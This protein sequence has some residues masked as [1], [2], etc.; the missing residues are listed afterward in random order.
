MKKKGG[1]ASEAEGKKAK[2]TRRCHKERDYKRKSWSLLTGIVLVAR[3]NNEILT[4]LTFPPHIGRNNPRS[5]FI[6]IRFLRTHS[7]IT[8]CE[9]LTFKKRWV[10]GEVNLKNCLTLTPQRFQIIRSGQVSQHTGCNTQGCLICK[11]YNHHVCSTHR[12]SQYASPSVPELSKYLQY[13]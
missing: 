10:K 6:L 11:Q 4:T 5:S 7:L 3:A 1:Y 9:A 8:W 13:D 2:A 12:H